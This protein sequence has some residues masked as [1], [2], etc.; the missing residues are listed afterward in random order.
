LNSLLDLSKIY[1]KKSLKER[2]VFFLSFLLYN[3][4]NKYILLNMKDTPNPPNVGDNSQNSNKKNQNA[5]IVLAA[6]ISGAA[7]LF[8]GSNPDFWKNISLS[9]PEFG[10]GGPSPESQIAEIEA[11]YSTLLK[12]RETLLARQEDWNQKIQ[13][14]TQLKAQITQFKEGSEIH[15]LSSGVDTLSS[16]LRSIDRKHQELNPEIQGIREKM[17]EAEKMVEGKVSAYQELARE[18]E[19][20]KDLYT[21]L[22]NDLSSISRNREDALH[23]LRD[24][25][26]RANSLSG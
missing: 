9:N 17:Q 22:Q 6:G 10:N 16:E 13:K 4:K 15:S 26:S 24:L 20:A 14:L 25:E 8:I 11:K 2:I 23:K 7:G 1:I 18:L 5:K 12:K 21:N 19:S 3:L